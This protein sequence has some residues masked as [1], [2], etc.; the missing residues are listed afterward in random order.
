MP[1][2]KKTGKDRLDKFYH[3]AKDQG[4]RA[5]SAFKL[6]QLAKKV[7]FLSK[8]KVCIDLCAAPGGW[9]QVA[10]RNMPHGSQILAIDLAPIKPLHG[11]TCIQ[12]DITTEKCRQL[13]RKELKGEKADAVLHD[14]APNVGAAWAKDAY[15]QNEL[16]LA[17]LKTACE[18]LRPGGT[19][20][21][22]VF[23][24]ADYNSLL[25][26]FNQLF[27]KVEATKPTASRNVSAEI[28]VICIQYKAGKVDPRFF[29]PKWV[30]METLDPLGD[31]D[32]AESGKKPSAA[33]SDCLRS[34]KKKNRSGYDTGE[35]MRVLSAHEFFASKK[36]AELLVTYNRISLEGSENEEIAK[37]EYTTDE[38]RDYCQDLKVLGKRDLGHLLKWKIKFHRDKERVEREAKKAADDEAKKTALALRIEA[39][40]AAKAT[41]KDAAK[42]GMQQDVD[43][44][45][46]AFLEGAE[47]KDEASD[48]ELSSE[49][50]SD[51]E[52][53]KITEELDE[54]VEKRRREE[55]IEAKKTAARQKKQEFRKK[56]SL[57]NKNDQQDEVELFRASNQR[58]VEALEDQDKYINPEEDSAD[59]EA[60]DDD[61]DAESDS[62]GD[63]DRLAKMEVDLAV[64]HQL[65]NAHDGE[66]FRRQI[67]RKMKKKKETRR[68]RLMAAWAGELGA[69]NQEIDD[70]AYQQ[71]MASYAK[72][73]DDDD[74]DDDDSDEE[75]LKALRSSQ[76]AAIKDGKS[77]GDIDAL[78]ASVAG[79][80]LSVAAREILESHAKKQAALQDGSN[81]DDEEDETGGA[82][83]S[84][85]VPVAERGEEQ[86]REQHRASRWFSQDIFKNVSKSAALVPL[87]RDSDESDNDDELAIKEADEKNLPKLPLTDKEKRK[88]ERQ[89]KEEHLQRLGKKPKVADTRPMEVAPL[90]APQQLDMSGPQ[91]PSD[92]RELAETMAL[93]SL[94]VDSKKSRMDL[95]DAG[96]NRYTF[97]GDEALPDWFTEDENRHNKPELPITKE[98]MDQFRAKLRE[99]NARPIRKVAEAKARKRRRMQMRM[100]KLRKSAM[101]MADTPEMSDGMKARQMRKAISRE[102]SKDQRKVQVVAIKKGG[103]G[104]SNM[105]GKVPKGAKL[106][107]VDRRAKSDMRGE[108]NAAK[109]NAGKAKARNRKQMIKKQGK[110]GRKF[111]KGKKSTGGRGIHDSRA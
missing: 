42:E 100:D 103:G 43:D 53:E 14:G 52:E 40:K 95:I 20:V 46:A 1:K 31:K 79:P 21:T 28:F 44:A 64:S 18:H 84:A 69:F 38:I 76:A 102:M 88:R 45:I 90:E 27:N 106:K 91:K 105:K 74:N 101:S 33:L 82:S 63:L 2:T 55:R 57:G 6:I 30:F 7:D 86:L 39:K 94:L 9:A 67:Q 93:G 109:R 87:D 97:D 24:S 16:T 96:Y 23:R 3:L 71:H 51:A 34:Q 50:D 41:A 72:D 73:M 98:L 22:K 92:P 99:I 26:V 37:H 104:I 111:G 62:D 85:L 80:D 89:Q 56:L 81:D 17:A 78:E 12:S 49:E 5:R 68:E 15:G 8:A 66:A 108:K 59:E 110:D 10:Q 54:L 32:G 19:F 75:D 58:S 11:V 83:S 4:Y 48:V 70:K 13:I 65:R 77:W 107:V 47:D 60:E 29:E 61:E 25:W 35:D 36:P